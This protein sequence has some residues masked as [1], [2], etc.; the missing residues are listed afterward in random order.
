MNMLHI[1]IAEATDDGNSQGSGISFSRDRLRTSALHWDGELLWRAL[2]LGFGWVLFDTA[3]VAT[4]PYI[5]YLR[6]SLG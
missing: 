3:S 4:S 2:S 5:H 6:K 1:Y